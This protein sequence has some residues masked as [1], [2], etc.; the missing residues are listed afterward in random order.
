MEGEEAAE[1]GAGGEEAAEVGVL[2]EPQSKAAGE[3]GAGVEVWLGIFA[4]PDLLGD[5]SSD[6]WEWLSG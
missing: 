1:A 5:F 4:V 6:F 3:A 2:R